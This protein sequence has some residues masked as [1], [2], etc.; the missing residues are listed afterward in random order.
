MPYYIK[1]KK[2]TTSAKTSR[3]SPT[4][5]TLTHRLDDVFSK[6]IRLRDA[7][8]SGLF[9]C[10]SCGQIKPIS[11][12]DCGHFHSRVHMNTRFDEDN[13]HAECRYCL[14]PDSLILMKD[15]T[16]KTLGDIQEGDEL[17]A[18]D[19]EVIYKTSRRY[20]I[21]KVTH[22]HRDVQDVYEVELENGDKVKTTANHKW[23]ARARAGT[24]YQWIET[25]DMWIDG[26]NLHGKRKTGPHTDKVTTIVCKPFQVVVQDNSRESGW[27]AG[28]IDADGHIT[29]QK[30]KNPD[31]TIRYGFRVG[32]AQC[33][34]YMD[35]CH[36]IKTLLEKFTGNNKTCRQVMEHDDPR[37]I[38]KKTYQAW[39]FLITGTNVEKI[40][41]L[42]KVRPLKI[43]KVDIE[44]LGKLK[45]QYDTK[46]KAIR[47]IGKKE[48]VVMETDTHTF[49]ANGYAM[50]NCNRFSADHI[51]GYRENLIKK[52]G[53]RRFTLLE[54]KAHQSKQ[55][56][57]FEIEQLIKYYRARVEMLKKEK[58]ID[59]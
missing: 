28:M 20:R 43:N 46:V 50:H 9:R 54:F 34:K 4:L 15:L 26:I 22:I 55:W 7:M 47:Y 17:F 8:P 58:G 56:A 10:I 5:S 19:E 13:C 51:I 45:S 29:Q 32:I 2:K 48:I 3:K 52:I 27:I 35:I 23:L 31:G 41:F 44:K 49:I 59:L 11:Q 36:E 40:Q 6:Y 30:I 18:F 24:S 37:G 14:T 33:E 16:W 39:Q 42:Q 53:E 38:F 57:H 21:G 1:R 12:A 25:Q